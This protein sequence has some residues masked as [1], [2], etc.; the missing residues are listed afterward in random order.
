MEKKVIKIFYFFSKECRW[1]DKCFYLQAL[2]IIR[3]LYH[4]LTFER[5]NADSRLVYLIDFN[6][7]IDV[8]LSVIGMRVKCIVNYLDVPQ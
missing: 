5:A 7:W 3:F 6:K 1:N 8:V 2:N 4:Y